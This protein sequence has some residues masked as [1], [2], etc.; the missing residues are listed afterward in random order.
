[1]AAR[2]IVKLCLIA[3][4]ISL[5]YL[6]GSHSFFYFIVNLVLY[7]C[8]FGIVYSIVYEDIL[9]ARFKKSEVKDNEQPRDTP[10]LTYDVKCSVPQ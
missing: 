3:G 7:I 1:M 2:L 8:L 9:K 10:K 6:F 4:L 5:S